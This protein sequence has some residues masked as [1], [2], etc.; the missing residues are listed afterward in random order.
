MRALL[1]PI[2]GRSSLRRLSTPFC[3]F[4]F[5]C[6]LSKAFRLY[7]SLY[8]KKRIRVARNG[9]R[10]I[11]F[12]L[13]IRS[14]L[15]EAT[16]L[17]F[18]V[19]PRPA[20][21]MHCGGVD[22]RSEFEGP[23]LRVLHCIGSLGGGGAERQLVY[24][25]NCMVQHSV[26]V[27]VAFVSEGHNMKFLIGG[28]VHLHRLKS[29]GNYDPRLLHRLIAVIRE[30]QPDVVQTWLP[31]M[32][33]LAGLAALFCRRPLLLTERSVAAAYDSRWREF[34][35][36]EIGKRAALVVANSQGGREYW[37]RD[38]PSEKVK[39]VR[40]GI[41]VNEYALPVRQLRAKD[42]GDELILFAGRYSREKNLLALVDALEI[43]LKQRPRTSA[44]L[45][46]EGPLRSELLLRVQQRGLQQRLKIEGYTNDLPDWMAKASVFVSLGLFEGCPNTVSEAAVAACPLVV[47]DIAPHRELLGGHACYVDP[48]SPADIARGICSVLK[49]THDASQRADAARL[50]LS[51][52]TV[53]SV[54]REY[55]RIYAQLSSSTS[56]GAP[57]S[58]SSG[59]P[60]SSSSPQ[61][62]KESTKQC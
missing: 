28:G 52:M 53:E 58:L 23:R 48:S 41:V 38:L 36:R 59:S 12:D 47:S 31:Q 60:A 49:D 30:V 39:L 11:T 16:E 2:I 17:I 25:S 40:N 29:V 35:R 15:R 43:V 26:D 33:I 46:G 8:H 27:H 9:F 10:I 42:Y 5:V 4:D 1:Q 14:D 22:T 3:E 21:D 44:L 13:R 54:T 19:A 34:L 45:F 20:G 50:S 55:L 37:L 32:D 57:I 56:F 51:G 62:L 24:L 7:E 6:S 61:A 18:R